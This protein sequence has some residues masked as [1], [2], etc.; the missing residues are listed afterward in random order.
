MS[1]EGATREDRLLNDKMIAELKAQGSFETEA[2]TQK[3][4]Q[5]LKTLQA[6][7]QEF[8]RI[9]SL[10][11]SMSEGMAR[12]AGGKIFTFGSYR[13]GVH[14][15]GSDI[16]TLVVAPKHVS[17][18]V[19]FE[20]F[21]ELL[22]KLPELEKISPVADAYVPIIK[23]EISGISIDLTF[24]KVDLPQVPLDLSLENKNLLRN[25]DE[26]DLRCINGTRVTDDILRLVPNG[27]VFKHALRAIKMWAQRRAIYSNVHGFPGGVAWAMMVARICQLY[28]NAV[29]A[30][31]VA[32][33]FN[34]YKQ[35]KWPQPV[36]LRNIEEGPLQV[37]VW[38]PRIYPQDRNHRMPI[39]TP[40]Y[41]SMCATHNIGP[42]T[43]KIIMAELER[44]AKLCEDI[45]YN[46]K[47]WHDFFEKHTFFHQYKHYLSIIAATRGS[48]EDHE[49]WAGLA[50]SKLRLL[51]QKL[52]GVDM[53]TLVH[54]YVKRFDHKY[55]CKNDADALK[56]AD[57][58]AV[59]TVEPGEGTVTV[60]TSIMYLALQVKS[61]EGKKLLISFPCQ[62]YFE[63]CRSWVSYNEDINS[64]YIKNVKSHELPDEVFAP[65]EE[66]PQRQKKRKRPENGAAA[67]ASSATTAVSDDPKRPR[68]MEG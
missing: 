40:A 24:S 16:D 5:V 45:A 33:F 28:P 3:R 59:E 34:I 37:R 57:G 58:H 10:R 54:P 27:T 15:P 60:Y 25:L 39:I 62:E 66:R 21:V 1:M 51:V 68:S 63:L 41:P 65:G 53:V 23:T 56:A 50:E 26:R 20:V 30:T 31:I 7:T 8:V 46:R 32:K 11:K 64:I 2:E 35:W 6:L 49:N 14:G 44:G 9:V 42:S 12:D 55:V 61:Q 18:E 48:S 47:T 19:F 4:V 17:R 43:Q 29:S 22:R 36:M 38:N 52:E 67:P 13:L